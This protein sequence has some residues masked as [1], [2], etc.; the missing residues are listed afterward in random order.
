MLLL[1]PH[2]LA[3]LPGGKPR[4]SFDDIVSHPR[5]PEARKVYFDRFLE[6]YGDDRFLVRLLIEAGRFLAFHLALVL[7]AS[8]DLDRRETWLT[9]GLLKKTVAVLTK[10]SDRQ[11]DAIIARLCTVGFLEIRP[12][13]QDRRVR[14]LRTTEKLRAHDRDW[15]AAHYAPLAVLYPQHGYDLAM[16]RDPQFQIAQRRSALNFISLGIKAMTVEPE[17][18]TFFSRTAG[19]PL[20]ATILQAA[21]ASPDY[22]HAAVPYADIGD[23]FGVSRTHV[24]NMMIEVEKLGVVKLHARGGQRVEILPHFWTK[25]DRGIA[26]GMFLHEVLYYALTGGGP[27]QLQAS[28]AAAH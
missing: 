18:I 23:R 24:R 6:L 7:E 21:M 1:E 2:E 12:S 22:P 4:V 5:F 20:L 9:V 26:G 15:L 27:S 3:L 13:E 19:Y 17:L 8:Q 14:I 16:R 28:A 11:V 10:V 25:H